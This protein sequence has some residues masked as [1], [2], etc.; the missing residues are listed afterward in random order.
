MSFCND[1]EDVH[2]LSLTGTRFLIVVVKRLLDRTRMD[3][4]K[5]GRL[6]VGTE[7]NSDKSKS[8]KTVL[9][10]LFETCGNHDIEGV[11][12]KNACYGG[13][14]ALFNSLSWMESSSWD[15]RYAIV[16]AAD[17]ATYAPGPARPTG[18]AGAIAILLGPDAPLTLDV[19]RGSYMRN[20]Y[21]FFKP[22]GSTD[23]PVVDGTMSIHYYH[24]ALLSAY[25]T[26]RSKMSKVI[27]GF[28]MK[29]IDFLAFHTPFSRLVEKAFARLVMYFV[30]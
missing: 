22:D 23:Y 17:I 2:S 30:I 11:D 7:T 5:I 24:A 19:F 26:Y 9:M 29:D 4:M 10:S 12:N 18:G 27:P 25:E 3:P 1:L 20:T 15:G 8:V 21:D 13:T 6:E 16:V 28:S 14:A